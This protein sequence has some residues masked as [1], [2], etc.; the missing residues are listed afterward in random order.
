MEQLAASHLKP[1]LLAFFFPLRIFALSSLTVDQ[2]DAIDL[3]VPPL[4]PHLGVLL[5][6]RNSGKWMLFRT[7]CTRQL[8]AIGKQIRRWTKTKEPR[9]QWLPVGSRRD[10]AAY[11]LSRDA[12]RHKNVAEHGGSLRL[13]FSRLNE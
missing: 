9:C 7:A 2:E 10:G 11:Q 1:S 13:V 6:G 8:V 3:L 5:A 12:D 4:G